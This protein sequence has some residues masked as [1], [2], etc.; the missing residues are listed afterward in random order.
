MTYIMSIKHL[1]YISFVLLSKTSVF[2]MLFSVGRETYSCDV[3]HL[4]HVEKT[5][6]LH[7]S[8][9]VVQQY[10]IHKCV[11]DISWPAV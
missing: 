2:N 10:P 1:L 3:L 11:V 9:R 8:C 6:I 4:Y 7:T 5:R